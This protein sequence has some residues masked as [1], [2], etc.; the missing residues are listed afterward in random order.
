MS[1]ISIKLHDPF[2]LLPLFF[3]LFFPLHPIVLAQAAFLSPLQ[4][5]TLQ[6]ASIFHCRSPVFFSSATPRGAGRDSLA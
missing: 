6:T 5:L 2:S 1:M 4:S 3:A